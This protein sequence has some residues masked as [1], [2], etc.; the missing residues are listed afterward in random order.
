MHENSEDR[1]S[2]TLCGS[3]IQIMYP[4]LHC[5]FGCALFKGYDAHHSVIVNFYSVVIFMQW[6]LAVVLVAGLIDVFCL[7]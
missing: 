3:C 4:S 2:G 1:Q 6:R 7:E 5:R